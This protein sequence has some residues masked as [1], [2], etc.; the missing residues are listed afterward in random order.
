MLIAGILYVAVFQHREIS[1]AKIVVYFAAGLGIMWAVLLFY[2]HIVQLLSSIETQYPRKASQFVM[3]LALIIYQCF[4][5]ILLA[6][7]TNQFKG[8]TLSRSNII[9][10]LFW[11]V[12][13]LSIYF[14]AFNSYELNVQVVFTG[15]FDE[16][17]RRY[18]QERIYSRPD[19]NI[20]IASIIA[21]SGLTT[22]MF[23][24]LSQLQPREEKSPG[25][26]YKTRVLKSWAAY[27]RFWKPINPGYVGDPVGTIFICAFPSFLIYALAVWLA[28]YV[29]GGYP[30]IIIFSPLIIVFFYTAKRTVLE[31]RELYRQKDALNHID[32]EVAGLKSELDS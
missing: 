18:V 32:G 11:A 23:V 8:K 5:L 24:V 1:A 14:A 29:R 26:T 20:N 13:I 10:Y 27:K 25:I 4:V 22:I 21:A 30:A 9:D 31:R 19:L 17:A 3:A 7:I 28:N 6:L 12:L 16:I 15:E 2:P